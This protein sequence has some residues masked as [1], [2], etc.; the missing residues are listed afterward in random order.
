MKKLIGIIILFIV[1]TSIR[2]QLMQPKDIP[3]PNASDLGKYGDIPVSYYTGQP[4][5]T[6]P[7]IT[8]KG[9]N[10]VMPVYMQYDASGVMVNSLPGWTGHNWT[11]AAGGSVTR[12]R[13]AQPD[14]YVQIK[15]RS[16]DNFQ[17]YFTQYSQLKNY[18][19]SHQ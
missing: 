18:I 17:N 16:S 7:I 5:I 2:A 8:L 3:T 4:N 9:R 19:S 11:L 14:E 1:T 15:R 10:M 12:I 13:N 6:V